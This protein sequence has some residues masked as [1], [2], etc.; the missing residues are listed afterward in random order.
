MRQKPGSL[1]IISAPSGA[2]KTT[3][4]RALLETVPG[5]M[6]SVS[7]TTRPPRPGEEDGINYHFVDKAAFEE[8]IEKDEF[9]EYARVFDHYY[10]TS[11]A[12]VEEQLARGRDIILEIDWQGARQVRRL[13]PGSI[14]IFI[15]P[16]S[17]D[18]LLERL[19]QRGD[20]PETVTRRMRDATRELSHYSEYDYL[21]L[22]DDLDTARAQLGDIVRGAA[23]AYRPQQAWFDELIGEM[24]RA[25]PDL[26]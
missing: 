15:L 5:L 8:L 17:C 10:G 19:Q 3:L 18:T 22:N 1:F 9:L 25:A 12:R 7:H 4:V 23:H 24:L 26:Q 21:V 20:A 11:R 13:M 14:G 6:V 2:G 16:P